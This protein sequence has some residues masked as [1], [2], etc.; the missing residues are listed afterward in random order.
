VETATVG[1]GE[2]IV[3]IVRRGIMNKNQGVGESC[4]VVPRKLLGSLESEVMKCMWESNEATVQHVAEVLNS[5]R[6]LAYTTVMTVMGHLVN[7]GLL[8]RSSEGRR[9]V[10]KVAQSREEFVRMAS[11]KVVRQALSDF[12]DMA[13]TSFI[14]EIGMAKPDKLVA[15]KALFQETMK[16]A[17]ATE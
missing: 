7:K 16:D 10:Y 5:G 9:Y 3:D 6:P 4:S 13:I 1:W 11:W 17:A 15:L 2:L 12:G 14:R 8:T